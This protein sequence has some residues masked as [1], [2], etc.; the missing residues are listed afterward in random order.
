MASARAFQ[1]AVPAEPWRILRWR[2]RHLAH[3]E[4][5]AEGMALM[6]LRIP[7]GSFLMGAPETKA[8]SSDNE[9]PVHRVTLGEFLL[10][11]TPVTQAQWRAVAQWQRQDHVSAEG[12]PETLDPDPVE[13]LEDAER[14]RGDHPRYCRSSYRDAYL[15]ASSDDLGFRVCCLPQD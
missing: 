15:P 14:F 12:W 3:R 1:Q 8:D 5:L 4:Q 9:R 11:Q 6:M 7:A 13:K 2:S 10:A